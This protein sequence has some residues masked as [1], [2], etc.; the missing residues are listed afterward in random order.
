[1]PRALLALGLALTL[2]TCQ[3]GMGPRV[4]YA[5]VA[6]API[7]PSDASVASYGLVIDRV[8]LVVVRPA[9][10]TLA[11]T[12]V[13][14]PPDS[15]A[16][17]LDL[18]VPLFSAAETLQVSIIALSGS[19]PLFEG[20]APVEVRTGG[21][22]APTTIPVLTYI[23]PGAGVD[24]IVVTPTAPFIYLY[25]S[26]RFQVQA[27]QA[28]VPVPQFYVAWSTSDS[29]VARIS[30]DGTLRAPA[31]R[32]SVRVV[33]RTPG[34]VSSA[35]DSTTV[36]FVPLP[37]QLVTI[38]G[39]GQT[40]VVSQPLATDLE[41]EVRAADNL[42]VGGV[43]VRFRSLAGGTPAD[44]IV[45]SDASGRARVSGVLGPTLGPQTFEAN[46]PAFAGVPVV[47]FGATANA[48]PIS[49]ATSVV[50]VSTGTI[51]SGAGVTVTLRG[52][53]AAGN[54][55]TVG[56]ATVVFTASGG[57]STGTIGATTDNGDGTYT[58]TFTGVGAG[59]ATTIGATI[60]GAPV[61]T[62][63]PTI[64][65]SPG[66]ISASTSVVTVSTGTVASGAT[67]ALTL[68]AKDAAGN[69]LP[70]GGATVVFTLSGG[71]STGTIGAT[72]DNGN[73]TYSATFTGVL[74][75]TGTTVSATVN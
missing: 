37:T 20:S 59:S 5:R 45:T 40:G 8:R 42:P 50:T 3:D 9:A 34:G 57:T 18:R 65:V 14:L 51:G 67:T 56:G 17:D 2:A 31:T 4:R 55:V 61:T 26:L 69:N 54:S 22:S 47:S 10:D 58:A 72:T 19:I 7:L 41:V 27:F 32:T 75:G 43:A 73:G 49:A 24:S 38:A 25:D 66:A 16:L 46:L 1:M 21:V 53:D 35:V 6:V 13:V 11:D 63:L 70:T 64:T 39:S 74:A 33:A 60:N 29:T 23:G 30:S 15:A 68:Q 12:T 62:A 28:G 36:T 52:K 71:T 48:G 44:T